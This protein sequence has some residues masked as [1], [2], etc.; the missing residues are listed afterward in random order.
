VAVRQ[1]RRRCG[2][3]GTECR[4]RRSDGYSTRENTL[5]TGGT[6]ALPGPIDPNT[7]NQDFTTHYGRVGWD[8][9]FAGTL[10]NHLNLGYNRTNSKN[11]S[12]AVGT[13]T[14]WGQKLGLGNIPARHFPVS[15]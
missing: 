13:G 8:H 3:N 15:T 6:P 5:L 10:L 9:T 2:R 11:N 14:N 12:A 1:P 4:S 7:W